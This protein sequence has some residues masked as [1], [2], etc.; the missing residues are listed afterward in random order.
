MKSKDK[1]GA[2]P[3]FYAAVNPKVE[4]LEYFLVNLKQYLRVYDKK[5]NTPLIMAIIARRID[6]IHYMLQVV[7]SAIKDKS[8]LRLTPLSVACRNGSVGTA[9]T[10]MSYKGSAPNQAGGWDKM[11]PL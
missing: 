6:L 9:R 10:L 4:C 7:P 2:T 3:I 8:I 5:S 11:T 1:L